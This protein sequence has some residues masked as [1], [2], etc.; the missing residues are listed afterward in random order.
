MIGF[1][2]NSKYIGECI[3]LS[4]LCLC[5]TYS[6]DIKDKRKHEIEIKKLEIK[7]KLNC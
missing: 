5:I 6:C 2:M 4:V 7:Q 1:V 3:V